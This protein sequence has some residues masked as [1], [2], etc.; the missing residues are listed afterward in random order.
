MTKQTETVSRKDPLRE[1]FTLKVLGVG[2]AGCN[3]VEHIAR[4]RAA[5]SEFADVQLAAVNTDLQSLFDL[6]VEC[7]IPLGATRTRGLGAG[8]DHRPVGHFRW[9]VGGA[10]HFGS[11]EGLRFATAGVYI[12]PRTL[13]NQ[14]FC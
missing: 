14:A 12:L 5:Q 11:H 4:Q 13:R 2:G 6:S 8:G 9:G 1:E 3:A 7:V 10:P